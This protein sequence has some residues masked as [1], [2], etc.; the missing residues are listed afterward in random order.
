MNCFRFCVSAL[1]SALV[2]AV[3][4]RANAAF[5][6]C[7]S[8]QN[9]IEAAFGYRGEQAE[10]ISEGWWQI[11][12]GQCARVYNKPLT[13]RFYFYF[14]RVLA[15]LKDGKAPTVWSGKYAFCTD[16]KAFKVEGDG[17]CE[18]RNYQ[19]KGFKEIDIGTDK[20]NYTLTFQD[21]SNK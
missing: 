18:S 15:P 19:E 8:T 4:A 7:N 1:L 10:W 11:Q 5:L 2:I 16:T 6:F 14:A 20:R 3:P 12:P 17:D 13:Q 21:V 9:S